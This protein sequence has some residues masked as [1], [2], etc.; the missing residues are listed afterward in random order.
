MVRLA[1]SPGASGTS[2]VAVF[3]QLDKW[4]RGSRWEDALIIFP[5]L[6]EFP[7][8][9]GK[10]RSLSVRPLGNFLGIASC[11]AGYTT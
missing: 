2:K 3:A 1:P 4:S 9:Y 11:L 6:S 10:R 5:I 7:N 8:R